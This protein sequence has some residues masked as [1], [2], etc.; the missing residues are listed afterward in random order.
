MADIDRV[1]EQEL[2]VQT[3]QMERVR[4][5]YEVHNI[6]CPR[7]YVHTY[8]CQQNVADSERMKGQLQQMGFVFTETPDDADLILLNTCAV[9]EHAQDRVF[10]NVGALKKL[11][12][13]NPRLLIA[14]CGCMV[15]QQHVADKLYRSY[16]FV[17][18]IFG[19]HVSHRLPELMAKALLEGRRVV[20]I[21]T[22]DGVIA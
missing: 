7:A 11:K 5:F 2:A 6:E 10:G 14:L 8:G 4:A 9:R 20:E 13:R 22:C 1:T 3:A 15:Q 17:G 18:L 12:R 16:P 21:P 19:T